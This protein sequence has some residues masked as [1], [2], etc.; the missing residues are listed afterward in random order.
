MQE[1]D[2]LGGA[3]RAGLLEQLAAAVYDMQRAT[4]DEEQTRSPSCNLCTEHSLQGPLFTLLY[5]EVV[6]GS[7]AATS[8]K[9]TDPRNKLTIPLRGN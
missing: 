6:L 4:A 9:P 8:R 3:G 1:D 2:V 5:D 7:A